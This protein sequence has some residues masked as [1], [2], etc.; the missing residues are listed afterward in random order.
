MVEDLR[1]LA[2]QAPFRVMTTR[3]GQ[4]LSVRMSA[5]GQLGW[6][7]DRRGYR[8]E[9]TQPD[10]RPWPPIPDSILAVWQAVSGCDRMPESCL[11]NLY[12]GT[13]RMGL[14]QDRDEAD[15]DCP[16]VSI[17]LGDEALFRIGQTSRGGPTESF[18]LR[19][20]DVLVMGGPARLIHHGVD[21]IRAGSSSLLS[22]GGRINLTLRVV[23]AAQ[24]LSSSVQQPD[25]T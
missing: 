10:G 7:S 8:Y 3:S 17:S 4:S 20:G 2:A 23:T 12:R 16:V 15:M 9:A 22:G 13:A 18:W 24:K 11:V 6:V 14:H 19:S 5:A 1:T 25:S 21:R